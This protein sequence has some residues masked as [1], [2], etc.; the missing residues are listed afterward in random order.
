M[1][2]GLKK[3]FLLSFINIE[4]EKLISLFHGIVHIYLIFNYIFY[5]FALSADFMYNLSTF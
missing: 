3:E 4:F 2:R 1:L 5:L